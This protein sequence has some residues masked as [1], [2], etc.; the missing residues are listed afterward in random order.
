MK[1]S[2]IGLVHTTQGHDQED[3][4]TGMKYK[5]L[6]LYP[7]DDN[8]KFTKEIG[9]LVGLDVLGDGNVAIVKSL[10]EHSFLITKEAYKHKY[11]YD[12][13]TKKPLIFRAI[14]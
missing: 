9:Q 13:K 7:I 5:L 6:V 8:G 10:D 3:F 14:E 2:R 4:L 11:P 1:K 12:W